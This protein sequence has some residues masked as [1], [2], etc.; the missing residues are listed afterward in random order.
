[1]ADIGGLRAH[2][3]ARF[4]PFYGWNPV[5]LTPPLPGEP[6]PGMRCIQTPY[7]DV[8]AGWKKRMGLRPQQTVSEQFAIKTEKNNHSIS[9][10]LAILPNEFISY[11][12]P[13]IGWYDHAVAAGQKLI[14][15]EQIDAIISSSYPVTC[16]LIAS[17]LSKENH[18]PWIADF[19]DLWTQNHYF[20]HTPLRNFFER[21]LELTTIGQASAL[22]TVSRPLANNLGKLHEGK[23]VFPVPNGFDPAILNPG[24]P[25]GDPFSIVYTGMLYQGKRDPAQL[26]LVLR[27]LLTERIIPREEVR[28]DLF[29]PH[30][31]WLLDEIRKFDLQ[32]IV[33]VHEQVPREISI[34]EQRKAQ[35]LLLLTWNDPGEA[36]VY[37]GK[38]FEYLAARRPIL[39]MGFPGG[40]VVKE[41][42][43]RTH[44]G[45][46]V[47]G[48]AGLKEYLRN[49]YREYREVG[50][51][52][53]HGIGDEVMK[54]S[55]EEMAGKFA[56]IL[57][58]NTR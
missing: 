16:H 52:S 40:G 22:T 17:T 1:M 7:D 31:D 56:E 19:R 46:H 27:E 34:A 48:T 37:T 29:G 42:L 2:G 15:K 23:Q 32:G 10:Y 36:G 18:L 57:Y 9:D 39:S 14:R 25:A 55:H 20:T 44:A 13:Q 26:F 4:L 43:D 24:V 11:P 12:D 50:E 54:Y 41:L 35:I 51:V 30:E 8:V 38:V 49:A 45:V 53:Y 47:S 33:H 21:R 5:V 6:D 58:E 3:L 28:I